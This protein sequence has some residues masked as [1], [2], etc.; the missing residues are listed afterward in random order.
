MSYVA[1]PDVRL[2]GSSDE[3]AALI[4]K[5]EPYLREV[6]ASAHWRVFAVVGHAPLASPPGT[7]AALGHDSLT[8][9]FA[10]AGRSVVRV[11][12][13]RYWTVVGGSGCV[14]RAPGGWTAV[15]VNAPGVVRVA[16]RFSLALAR[17]ALS[18]GSALAR[19]G[20]G[21]QARTNP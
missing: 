15:S 11:R 5:R 2:D 19:R 10:K 16:A 8:L 4:R 1:L 9:R 21:A 7:L 18:L 3:E 6:F 14:R 12:Y 17:R 13:T 20:S